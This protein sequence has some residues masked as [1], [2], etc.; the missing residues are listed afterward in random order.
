[1]KLK[2]LGIL[3]ISMLLAVAVSAALLLTFVARQFDA[4]MQ[5]TK[6][7]YADVIVPLR[8]IDANTKNLRFH[9]LAAFAHDPAGQAA[10]LHTHPLRAHSDVIAAATS[11]NAALWRGVMGAAAGYPEAD[12]AGLKATYDSYAAKGIAPASDAVDALAWMDIVRT[13]TASLF[14]YNKFEKDL[15]VMV[16]A[17][18]SREQQQF[19]DARAAQQALLI[20][21]IAGGLGLVVAGALLMWRAVSGYTGRLN[22]AV[23]VT[24]AMSGG[25]LTHTLRTDGGCEAS[26]MLRAMA[27]MQDSLCDLVGRIRASA[28]SIHTAATEVA[29]GNVDLSARTEQQAGALQETAASMEELTST[30]RQN[31]ENAVEATQLAES[32]SAVARSGGAVVAQVVD[33]MAAINDSAREIVN[34]IAVIDGIAFQ[35]NILAL[36]AAVE[37]ARAGEQGRGFA[38][39]ASE[40]RN[41]AQRS[42][43]AAREIKTLI[44][45]SVERIEQGGKLANQAG[46][47]MTQIVASVGHVNQIIAE[48]TSASREQSAG[49][50]QINRAIIQI[51]DVT[52][53]NAALVEQSA[54]A[55]MSLQEQAQTLTAAISVFT[56]DT[57][58]PAG[59]KAAPAP[60]GAAPSRQLALVAG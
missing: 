7:V 16:G 59:R 24:G 19:N 21:A 30:V 40:V 58:A 57:R 20:G 6:G 18:E 31:A 42:A 10:T 27:G 46:E 15:G 25:D 41:L 53:Q 43:T 22:Q 35:T 26:S 2:S 37:A 49:I 52:Q 28:G 34:I 12:L 8:Q 5:A 13:V 39:V 56:I 44:G 33:T 45:D 60:R 50:D 17:L 29:A 54:A 32:A 14:E 3:M 4:G 1:M 9:L 47:T 55:A 48:I 51:D 36:N 11:A 38:V 23:D